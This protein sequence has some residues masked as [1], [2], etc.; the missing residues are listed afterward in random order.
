MPANAI[1]KPMK[2]CTMR[3]LKNGAIATIVILMLVVTT[4]TLMIMMVMATTC[5]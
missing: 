5:Q 4:M 2:Q 3:K 1:I